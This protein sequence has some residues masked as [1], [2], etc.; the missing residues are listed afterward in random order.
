M[1]KVGR[2]SAFIR[3]AILLLALSALTAFPAGAQKSQGVKTIAIDAG[4]GGKD[5]GT[6]HGEY[7]EKDINLAVALEL[8]SMIEKKLKDVKVVYTRKTDVFIPL[9]QRSET[10]NKA[11]ADLFLSIHVN[12]VDK[13][14][15]APSG[16]LSLV[17]GQ[18]KAEAN[19]DIAMRENDVIKY[20]EDYTTKYEGYI[21]GS[22]ESFIIFS[23]MQ[24]VNIEQSM[25]LANII[26][27]HYKKSTPMPDRG[28]RQQ[29]LLVLWKIT[30]PGVLTELGFLSNPEDRKTLCTTDGQKKLAGALF[31][32]ICEYKEKVEGK[33]VTLKVETGDG[34]TG[35]TAVKAES[36]DTQQDVYY[37]VQVCT[38]SKRLKK[39]GSELR[40]Y[41]S[42]GITERK[43]GQTYKYYAGRCGSYEEAKR[44]QTE[45]REIA[46]DAFVA[47]FRGEEQITVAE[48]REIT[49]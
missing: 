21:P 41:K 13:G 31:A 25:S 40:L 28:A 36:G 9:H 11:G 23:L 29:N 4:H 44:L 26:Q 33:S 47:A 5:P 38:S 1:F 12:A 30:M 16:A 35:E 34:D 42:H 46:P 3:T 49:K 7:K 10:A 20:E 2:N 27:G 45:L 6:V 18:D 8:G 24:Y 22:P 19:L 32:A 15:S 43:V 39:E 14:K 48:A 17:M 37:R